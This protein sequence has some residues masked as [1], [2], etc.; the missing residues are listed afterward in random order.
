MQNKK[1][2]P[3]EKFII[4]LKKSAPARRPNPRRTA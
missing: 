3:R 1:Q 2:T 4:T